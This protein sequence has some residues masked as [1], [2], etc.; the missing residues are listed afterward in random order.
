MAGYSSID[1]GIRQV[2]QVM[3]GQPFS[4]GRVAQ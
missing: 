4:G 2:V 3:Y 1:S